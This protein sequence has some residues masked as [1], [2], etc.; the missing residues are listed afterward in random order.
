MAKL[1]FADRSR[2]HRNLKELVEAFGSEVTIATGCS[3]TDVIVLWLERLF[4]IWQTEFGVLLKLRHLFSVEIVDYK[5]SFIREHFQPEMMFEDLHEVGPKHSAK[6]LLSGELRPIPFA[7]VW[8]CGIECDSL[9]G[10]SCTAQV[11]QSLISK[12]EGKTGSTARSCLEY[13]KRALPILVVLENIKNLAGQV[14]S[15]S[16]DDRTDLQTLVSE[17]NAMG[18]IVLHKLLDAKFYGVPQSR[19]RYYLLAVL[20]HDGTVYKQMDDG[21]DPTHLPPWFHQAST[22]MMGF[23]IEEFPISDFL[24]P[25][26]M[27]RLSQW[28]D[29]MAESS[30]EAPAASTKNAGKVFEVDHL[31]APL[32]RPQVTV[33]LSSRI[34]LLLSDA[35]CHTYAH[36]GFLLLCIPAGPVYMWS[37]VR[38]L[39]VRG[40]RSRDH[41]SP[42]RFPLGSY[43]SS[44]MQSVTFTPIRARTHMR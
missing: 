11:G 6:D 17:L 28:L 7:K 43:S 24:L 38:H 30:T 14:A 3:G 35:E 22:M 13:I 5:Q 26:G 12:G 36:G 21:F 16:T 34:F 41:M 44:C 19:E 40:V 15:T 31:Q 39:W 20:C 33:T 23:Q 37:R 10:L 32:P 8:A 29:A 4:S 2:A 27:P 9:S 25:P 1:T 18:Y 42:L